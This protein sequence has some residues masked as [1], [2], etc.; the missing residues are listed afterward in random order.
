MR[1]ILFVLLGLIVTAGQAD[2][3][4]DPVIA[5]AIALM[6]AMHITKQMENIG[7]VMAPMVQQQTQDLMR[8]MGADVSDEAGEVLGRFTKQM[9]A[10]SF[11]PE[12]IQELRLNAA[13]VY[14]NIF[15][16]EELRGF[17]TFYQSDLGQSL[18]DKSPQAAQQMME[19]TMESQQSLMAEMARLTREMEAELKAI[20]E[21]QTE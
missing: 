14:A 10:L 18:L 9:M 5:E 3:K 15:T 12:Q 17:N 11:S 8:E 1:S 7:A 21:A 4:V 13:A 19:L 16:L 6:D 20:T 2:E